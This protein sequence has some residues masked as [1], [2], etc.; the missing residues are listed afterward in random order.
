MQNEIIKTFD[1]DMSN[2]NVTYCKCNTTLV[3]YRFKDEMLCQC[4]K[5]TKITLHILFFM[6]I[7]YHEAQSNLG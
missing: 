5:A 7:N 6:S 1:F 3:I 4:L 2:I